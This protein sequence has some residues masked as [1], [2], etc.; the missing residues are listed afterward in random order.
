VVVV[1]VISFQGV[2]PTWRV[3]QCRECMTV[4]EF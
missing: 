2:A 1:M 3:A 4:L